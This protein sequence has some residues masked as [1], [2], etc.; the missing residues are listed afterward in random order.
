MRIISRLRLALVLVA[1]FLGVRDF[2]LVQAQTSCPERD[3]CIDAAQAAYDQQIAWANQFFMLC[4]DRA[5][6][7]KNSCLD[8]ADDGYA[9]CSND[10]ASNYWNGIVFCAFAD[11]YQYPDCDEEVMSTYWS[12]M[13][14]CDNQHNN[15]LNNCWIIYYSDGQECSDDFSDDALD[16]QEALAE[17]VSEC[18]DLCP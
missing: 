11:P 17:Q 2:D 15:D 3:E 4:A 9:A 18:N 8:S 16:A 12:E 7:I 10:A 1:C 14:S 13:A 5:T 6:L